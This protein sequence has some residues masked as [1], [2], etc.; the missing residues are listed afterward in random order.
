MSPTNFRSL[1][2]RHEAL[3]QKQQ[4]LSEENQQ[5]FVKE[6]REY[7]EEAKRGGSYISANRERD[8]IRAN[9]RYWANYIY[10]IEKTFPDTELAPSSVESKSFSPT[11]IGIIAIF[12]LGIA[13]L[14]GGIFALRAAFPSSGSPVTETALPPNTPTPLSTAQLIPTSEPTK[15]TQ[16][17]ESPTP[18]SSGLNVI[19]SSPSNGD[20]ITPSIEF[21]GTFE[22]L[23]PGWTIHVLFIK[24]NTFFPIQENYPIPDQPASDEWMIQTTLM[25][26]PEE[27][28][29]AQSYSVVLAISLDDASR[30][31]LSN[32]SETGI[33]INSLPSTVITFQDTSRVLYR[34]AYTAIQE[35]RLIYSIFYENESSYDLYTSKPDGTEARRIKLTPDYSEIYPNLSPDG[36]KIVYVKRFRETSGGNFIYT[37]AIMDSNGEN[38]DEITDRTTNVLESPQWSPDSL[39]ISYA[40]G[41]PTETGNDS[42][43]SVHIFKLLTG[44]D[45][46][47]SVG[48]KRLLNT[49]RYYSWIPD[50]NNIV[51]NTRKNNT[52]TSG[53]VQ[54]SIDAPENQSLLF[55]TE[56]EEIQPSIKIL[57]N[58]Y[59][60]TYT[61]ASPDG[62]YH[63]IYAILDSGQ[64]LPLDDS[65]SSIRLTGK[66]A[67][68]T[69]NNVKIGNADF[70]ISDPDSNSIYYMR[71]V[72]IYKVDFSIT[73]GKI[74]IL[75]GSKNDSELYG[76]LVI[77]TGLKDG[78]S[79]FDV[80]F[81]EAFFPKE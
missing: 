46:I 13:V 37:I 5:D 25:E 61:V 80:G 26:S 12:V 1:Q 45:K 28:G 48:P 51:F 50:S 42:Y 35:T 31:L 33:D 41:E 32:S 76:D 59:L 55:D 6:V 24:E 21:K 38:D 73:G 4:G 67:G 19:L 10:S 56:H 20:S 15:V 29:K 52:A 40:M 81:M 68:E 17:E 54:I 63:D 65:S 69:V 71:N 36:T 49:Y 34:K 75:P 27:M 47:V 43:W 64:Q 78:I 9:L 44:E 57:E 14:G 16:V 58:E 62:R 11:L 74:E 22:N 2:D 53:F 8:Q 3:L 77:E 23:K 60:L 7:I 72:N 18:E 79:G 66:R 30:E 39:Y 70:P